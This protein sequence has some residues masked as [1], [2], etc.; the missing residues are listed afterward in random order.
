M[1]DPVWGTIQPI[2]VVLRTTRGFFVFFPQLS[3]LASAENKKSPALRARDWLRSVADSNRRKR[4]CRPLPS[5]SV[6]R[7]CVW[8]AK[9]I[10]FG[11]FNPTPDH[12][13]IRHRP[14]FQDPVPLQE[15]AGAD[16]IL[17]IAL[18]NTSRLLRLLPSIFPQLL[19][20]G[21]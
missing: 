13:I 11:I 15:R 6:N 9:I 1:H 12:K 2:P 16:T 19:F 14:Q 17:L 10:K 4:F 8:N 7:P 18:V 3:K 21:T 5:H 20:Y